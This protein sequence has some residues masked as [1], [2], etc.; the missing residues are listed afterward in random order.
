MNDFTDPTGLGIDE[1]FA[2]GQPVPRSEDPVLLRGEGHYSD[3]VSRPGQ[4]YAVMVRSPHAHGVIRGIDTAAARAMPGVLA[5]YTAADL[6]AGGIGPLPARQV[7]NNRD[8]TPML[9]P[10]AYPLATAKVRHVGEAVAA[11]VAESVAA[12]KDAAE[13]VEL[14]IDPLPAVTEPALADAPDA[15]I[16][17]DD[18]PGNVGLDFHFGDSAAVAAAF[19]G[20]AH[21]TRLRAAQQPHRRQPDGAARGARRIRRRAPAFHP[22]CRL[23]GRVRLSQLCRPGARRR[24]R[25]AA[26]PDR[27]GRRLVR[28]EAADLRRILLH[29]ARRTRIG[30]PGQMDRRALGQLRLR[31]PRPRPPHDRRIGARRATAIS[32]PCA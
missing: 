30:P 10:A 3:D 18:V 21:V 6:E 20:A 8:G 13:L 7:M 22:A 1:K 2:I 23:P 5:V 24:P 15:P 28:H 27:P 25:P 4:A 31:Q 19:A 9:T 29:P 14:D 32:L 12:A 11:V 17:Y 16:L 26:H